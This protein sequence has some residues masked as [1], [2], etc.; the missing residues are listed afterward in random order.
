MAPVKRVPHALAATFGV[1]IVDVTEQRLLVSTELIR[2][3][4]SG[5]ALQ[6]DCWGAVNHLSILYVET[7]HLYQGTRICAITGEE[8]SNHRHGLQRVHVELFATA[9]EG[10]VAHTEWVDVTSI[11]IANTSVPLTLVIITTLSA[12]TTQLTI[13]LARVWCVRV[14]HAVGLPNVHLG[15]TRAIPA[16]AHVVA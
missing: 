2:N 13:N 16:S 8:L 10:V 11:F 3:A 9:E 7:P 15:T 12:I 4:V 14:G 1:I 6:D 5:I